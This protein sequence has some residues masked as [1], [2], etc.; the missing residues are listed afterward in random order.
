MVS[1]VIPVYNQL[2]I[3]RECVTSIRETAPD[4]VE[5]I[6][7]DNGSDPP[8]GK[9]YTGFIPNRVIRNERNEGF[10][11]AVNQG[12]REATGDVIALLNSDVILSPMW[13]DRLTAPLD[14]Y[15]I[16]G[17]V[18]NYASGI[19]RIIP[20]LYETK[21]EFNKTAADVWENYGNEVQEVN[22]LIGFLMVFKR[23][24]WEEIGPFDESLWPCSGEE[25]DFCMKARE[26]GHR[27]GVV[28]GCY[29]HHEGS[30]TFNEMQGKGEVDYD[31]VVK[32]SGEHL[33]ERWGKDIFARQEISSSPAP[34]GLC[35]NLGCGYG[36][37]EG[38]V[39]IDN[40]EEVAP[41]MV[42]DVLDGL[43][44]EDGSVD[45]VR[46]DDFLEHIPI[47]KTI[48]V[49]TE[50]WR[51]LKPGGIF[52]SLTPSTD[53]RGA[54]QDPTHVSFW[55]ANSWLYYTDPESRRL[56]G[57]VPDFE[58]VSIED[59][60]TSEPLQIIHTHAILKARKDA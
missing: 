18:T 38:F 27:V 57:M 25:I 36:H 28:L 4:G 49:V 31:A 13:L 17:P 42:C 12:I 37:L 11:K 23:S 2:E 55:N 39:N 60:V 3:F 58:V 6:V 35:L 43:P 16:L 34:K 41:D 50:I 20:G 44:Y 33:I 48:Q 52:E 24:L 53:G 14:E 30:R 19:Q 9:I 47:G 15:D 59:R 1:I 10:P 32:A 5:I 29:V 8:V 7:I 40:R 46:A 45:M 56:Y 21:D 54:F 26:K 51:V 22:W